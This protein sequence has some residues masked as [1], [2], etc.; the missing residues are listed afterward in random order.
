MNVN[1]M[2]VI[3]SLMTF[4]MAASAADGGGAEPVSA[5][6]GEQPW[7]AAVSGFVEPA[8]G[9]HPR[10]FMRKSDLPELKKRAQ[11]PEGKAIIE[12]L[13]FL[14]D[15]KNGDTLPEAVNKNKPVNQGAKGGKELP[16]IAFTMGHPAGYAMLYQLTGEQKYADLSRKALEMMFAG[17]P[18]R[19]ERYTWTSAGAGLRTGML[20]C[21]VAM[22]YDLA[23]DGWDDA[24]RRK[25]LDEIQDYKHMCV[26]H[27]G[28][29]GGTEGMTLAK[30]VNTPYIPGS[31]HY[32]A[33]QGGAA[34]AILA[35]RHDPGADDKKLDAL[36]ANCEKNTIT[37][38]TRAFGDG[39]YFAE[40]PGP[41][42][43]AA[44]T[45]L[46]PAFQAWRN[47]GGKDFLRPKV[48][49]QWLS[50][51]WAFE[52]IPNADG[53]PYYPCRAPSSYGTEY[54]KRDGT[55]DGGEFG[56][57]F[58]SVLPEQVPA[59]LWT[60]NHFVVPSEQKEYPKLL[61]DNVAGGKSYDALTYPHRAALSLMTFPIGVPEKNPA[62]VLGHFYA[63][64]IH[65]YYA[66]R[67]RW[68]D[69]EDSIVTLHL[70]GGPAGFKKE[71]R[72]GPILIWALG[73]R[74]TFPVKMT[75]K[76]VS[77]DVGADGSGQVTIQ[78]AAGVCALAIDY[79]G[80]SGAPVLVTMCAPNLQAPG[81]PKDKT[82]STNLVEAGKNKFL[83]LT[84]QKENTP[85]P[86]AQGEDVVIGGQKLSFNGAKI[87]MKVYEPAKK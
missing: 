81:A 65:N 38:L 56:Q 32:G 42:H 29:E 10:L 63:D 36:L 83:I 86:Q 14:L 22:A 71:D 15:G 46:V 11:T 39:G 28:F 60:Y 57:G 34:I 40:G 27:G 87:V 16:T 19:D 23:Y 66:F 64:H 50:L 52:I 79:S 49:A 68:Q 70:G 25:A 55:S 33:Y 24:F 84:V 43:M 47:A 48:N 72:P 74:L 53:K 6:G 26:T 62:D 44:N 61:P 82:I 76:P 77:V 21:C 2:I 85:V 80:A 54:V 3:G 37:V 58:G 8:A 75:G 18:D 30:M 35:I 20:M 67:N 41:S 9:E 1:W 13:R 5:A 69:H 12:R 17:T 51:R 73:K 78:T 7:P 4:A 31:N 59:M 45:S